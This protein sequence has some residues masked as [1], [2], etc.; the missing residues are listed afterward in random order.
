MC[1]AFGTQYALR[2]PMT[3]LGDGS[4]VLPRWRTAGRIGYAA[5]DGERLIGSAFLMRW[6]SLLTLGPVSV[7]PA[8]WSRGVARALLAPLARRLDRHDGLA[9]LFTRPD[10]P[11]HIRLYEDIGFRPQQLIALMTVPAAAGEDVALLSA[12]PRPAQAPMLDACRGLADGLYPG[13]DPTGEIRAAMAQGVGD[14]ALLVQRGR[15][16]GFALVHAGPGSE[17]GSG[18]LLV[19]FA[20]VAGGRGRQERL[21]GIVMACRSLAATIGAATVIAGVNTARVE[22]YDV[23]RS[24][25]CRTV[26]HGVAMTR[27][28][29]DRYNAP[30]TCL[31]DDWR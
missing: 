28:S 18:R 3:F 17:C 9:G 20:A 11:K 22:A 30:D 27:R 21:A 8:Y 23:L 10:S 31:L 1:L 19:K 13:L 29:D 14:A 15:L 16:R 7:D 26:A 24:A 4:Y 2:D 5:T 25:G 6:G 12:L